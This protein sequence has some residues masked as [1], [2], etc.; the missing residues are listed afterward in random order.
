[1]AMGMIGTTAKRTTIKRAV[2]DWI[3]DE[4]LLP[5]DRILGNTRL[6]SLL[7]TTPL[8]IQRALSE[9]AAEGR[10]YR[11]RGA[12][13]YVGGDPDR[14]K[15]RSVGLILPAADLDRPER[16]PHRWAYVQD[17]IRAFVEAA[18]DAW[19]FSTQVIRPGTP[20][21][22]AVDALHGLDAVFFHHSREPSDL[23]RHLHERP[24][25]P[26]VSFGLRDTSVPAFTLVE[27]AVPRMT[28][29]LQYLHRCGYRHLVPVFDRASWGERQRRDFEE[30]T[31]QTGLF[32]AT[33]CVLRVGPEPADAV[34][35]VA[36]LARESK[37]CDVL[38]VDTDMH[39][40][41]LVNALREAGR[42]VPAEI[43]VMG[44]TGLHVAMDYPPHLTTVA[45]A[46]PEMIRFALREIEKANGTPLPPMHTSFGGDVAPGR[47]TRRDAT[48][49]HRPS[50]DAKQRSEASFT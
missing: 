5:G 19:R 9:L 10:I 12:G 42:R 28:V 43:G 17:L 8:T 27:E 18:G 36:R 15:T 31:R 16:N 4:A 3:A 25:V 1:M 30:T 50:C 2:L 6:A 26:T 38:L 39:A 37:P 29:A 48:A 23:W 44:L 33:P 24:I 40:L 41:N 21:E 22:K 13:T 49:A 14:P 47:T 34:E 32:T 11:R 45:S 46:Y 7:D 20:P 35:A